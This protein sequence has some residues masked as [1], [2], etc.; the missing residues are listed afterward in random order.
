MRHLWEQHLYFTRVDGPSE[1]WWLS[2]AATKLSSHSIY[3]W[4][5]T[6]QWTRQFGAEVRKVAFTWLLLFVV[7]LIVFLCVCVVCARA[8]ICRSEV[9]SRMLFLIYYRVSHWP[10]A[11]LLVLPGWPVTLWIHLAFVPNSSTRIIVMWHYPGFCL[12][13]LWMKLRF[14]CLREHYQPWF[15]FLFVPGSHIV[16]FT[17]SVWSIADKGGVSKLWPVLFFSIPYWLTNLDYS[18]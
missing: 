16:P 11:H 13:V 12:H 9:K 17:I 18:S 2:L 5:W 10:E 15:Y 3:L 6:P 14:S 1:W 7:V 4:A 8:C